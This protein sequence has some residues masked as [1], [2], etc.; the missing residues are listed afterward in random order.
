LVFD[1][2]YPWSTMS[3]EQAKWPIWRVLIGLTLIYLVASS[4][5]LFALQGSLFLFELERYLICFG[6]ADV[7][8]AVLFL[9]LDCVKVTHTSGS[10]TVLCLLRA[11]SL[12]VYW[13]WF[14]S[15]L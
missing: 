4:C 10:V 8:L 7:S 6:Y 2:F 11:T 3:T 14:V 1:P 5:F 15:K 13:L 9:V 12:P